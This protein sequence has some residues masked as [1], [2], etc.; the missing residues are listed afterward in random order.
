MKYSLI[1]LSFLFTS[2]SYGQCAIDAYITAN[3]PPINGEYG[4]GETI[5]FCVQIDNW[6][7]V[8]L[9]WLHSVVPFLEGDGWQSGSLTPSGQPASCSGTGQWIWDSSFGAWGYDTS[10]NNQPP[11]APDGNPFNNWGDNFTGP[12]CTEYCFTLTT[13]SDFDCVQ[14]A[15]LSVIAGINAHSETGNWANPAC[16]ADEA[17]PFFAT[18]TC[19][20]P[21]GVNV[22]S[23][24]PVCEGS[25]VI[26]NAA[27]QNSGSGTPIYTV[28]GPGGFMYSGSNGVITVPN[29][30][31]GVYVVTVNVDGCESS[32]T[33]SI[34]VLTDD[35]INIFSP[36][37]VCPGEEFQVC[38]DSGSPSGGTWNVLGATIIGFTD[39]FDCVTIEVNPFAPPGPISF[40]YSVIVPNC[41][42]A[43]GMDV[44]NIIQEPGPPQVQNYGPFCLGDMEFIPDVL[45]VINT[46]S[47]AASEVITWYTDPFLSFPIWQNSPG[48]IVGD[49]PIPQPAIE[50]NLIN[51]YTIYVTTS[52]ITTGCESMPAAFTFTIQDCDCADINILDNQVSFCESA[53]DIEAQTS[54]DYTLAD[55]IN[56]ANTE[57][58]YF[59]TGGPANFYPSTPVDPDNL[60]LPADPCEVTEE[61]LYAYLY[62][63]P[64][65]QFSDPLTNQEYNYDDTYNFLGAVN[66]AIYPDLSDL[67]INF[68]D[69]GGCCPSVITT[70]PEF[71]PCFTS[72]HFSLVNDLDNMN[73]WN[74]DCSDLNGS[75]DIT[76]TLSNDDYPYTLGHPSYIEECARKEFI[77]N[78]ECED[79]NTSCAEI[80]IFSIPAPF[81]SEIENLPSYA[82]WDYTLNPL[83]NPNDT[84]V[85]YYIG[86][87]TDID[88]PE[89]EVDLT[90]F[91]L[92]SI[93]PCES[94]DMSIYA[95]LLCTIGGSLDYNYLGSLEISVYPDISNLE[96]SFIDE[97]GCCPSADIGP[98][99]FY[100]CF[101]NGQYSFV[102]DLD[103]NNPWSPDCTELDD[104]GNIV[105]SLV[106]ESYPLSP[107]DANY[108]DECA[109]RDFVVEYSCIDPSLNRLNLELWLEGPGNS[110]SMSSTLS[111]NGLLPSEQPFNTAP[112]FYDGSESYSASNSDIIDWLYVE[113]RAQN[114]LTFV[115]EKRAVLLRNDGKLL[116]IDGT[117]GIIFENAV[118]G[119]KYHIAIY[120]RGHLAFISSF[121]FE[122]PFVGEFNFTVTDILALGSE[123]LK[124]V[125]GK[126]AA[127]AG[128]F[129]ADGIINTL[130]FNLWFQNSA[131]TNVYAS[132]DVDL[133]GIINVND[134]TLWFENRSKVGVSEIMW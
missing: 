25:P 53:G 120:P 54:F 130:D 38:I 115:Y 55:H 105:F 111:I 43:V 26:I 27:S 3:P 112:Y 68:N 87:G 131:A 79:V 24:S 100:P 95:Y 126:Y 59:L 104:S 6:V 70:P 36:N 114:D 63:N 108:V 33:I 15:D 134:F 19:C 88:M 91:S 16:F 101:T 51:E 107:D 81:C 2:L 75:G 123:Q 110:S 58:Q 71:Y 14:G 20:D 12:A 65:G 83:T 92:A 98:P 13:L 4:P 30:E 102:N 103:P 47:T 28:S 84:Q 7:Q 32:E 119:E 9:N 50:P 99:D 93:D 52:S 96:L 67:Q 57:V 77:V 97:G 129:N 72:G 106:N 48:T 86:G 128:D 73:P 8:N 40:T 122:W 46:S 121:Y 76:F 78:Y 118:E 1:L 29:P 22:F 82:D 132:Y 34:G 125:N 18:L 127:Y 69:V 44:T 45:Q 10:L 109:R 74:P 89:T 85:A 60:F 61:T 21:P 5:E 64:L 66:I 39:Y 80:N 31:N 124:L 94:N 11:G 56:P 35:E 17:D 90:N 49:L 62:C 41:A 42:P 133:N 116:D 117:E 37:A 113:L 23:N